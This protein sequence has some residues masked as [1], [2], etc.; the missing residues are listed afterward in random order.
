MIA[1]A[2]SV[3]HFPLFVAAMLWAHVSGVEVSVINNVGLAYT[4]SRIVYAGAYI[5]ITDAKLSLLRGVAWWT[6]NVI[7][8]RA[9]WLGG[10]A[11][12]WSY[13]RPGDKVW[14]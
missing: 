7:C 5:F 6:S 3:E 4:I 10:K 11:M 1:H 12:N 2:N 13:V 8:L 14:I 9:L